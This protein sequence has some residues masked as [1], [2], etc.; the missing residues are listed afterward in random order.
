M[1][2]CPS[3]GRNVPRAFHQSSSNA[4]V[5]HIYIRSKARAREE[6]RATDTCFWINSTPHRDRP[7]DSRT[8]TSCESS[9]RLAD[10]ASPKEINTYR[11][12]DRTT[13]K[14]VSDR[15]AET[16][17]ETLENTETLYRRLRSFF[18]IKKISKIIFFFQAKDS[19]GPVETGPEETLVRMEIVYQRLRFI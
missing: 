10:A 8:I 14:R 12:L 18:R 15:P 4:I 16:A 11:L 2:R 7:E 17:H 6:R 5:D 9:I 1:V 13:T 3:R 19:F